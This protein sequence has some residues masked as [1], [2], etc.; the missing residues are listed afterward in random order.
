VSYP[1]AM[2]TAGTAFLEALQEAD[3]E[4]MFANLGSDHTALIEA[5][6]AAAASGRSLPKLITCPHEMVALRR[7]SFMSNAARNRSA[8]RS[9]TPQKAA[10]RS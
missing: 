2:Y 6:A 5:L 8:A 9:T 1:A 7:S 4:Y 3:I 10:S